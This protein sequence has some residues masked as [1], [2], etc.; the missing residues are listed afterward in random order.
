MKCLEPCNVR[1][2]NKFNYS[3]F[4]CYQ[5][6]YNLR[7]F[8]SF[9]FSMASLSSSTSTVN[10]TTSPSPTSLTTIHHLITIKLTCDNY[11]VWKAPI[12][13][14]FKGKHLYG[15]LKGNTPTP[16]QII[17]VSADGATQALQNPEFQHWHLQDQMILGALISS[18]SEKILAHVV[19]FRD[20]WQAL[21]HMFTSQSR[22]RTMQIHY[23]LAIL[24][25]DNSSVADYFHQFTTLVNTLVAI[26]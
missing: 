5:S 21:E 15:Y 3:V 16:S 26:D 9:L 18:L 25:K 1:L 10:T 2:K 20:V 8:F 7:L 19:K 23:Q 13:P 17:I 22:A 14:F 11:L 12:V 6:H 24:K 4:T